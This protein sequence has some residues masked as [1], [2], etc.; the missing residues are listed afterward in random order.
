MPRQR[1]Q[2][3]SFERGK[4]LIE[5][6]IAT[7]QCMHGSGGPSRRRRCEALLIGR[8]GVEHRIGIDASGEG[9]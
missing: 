5:Q 2:P 3:G 1:Q 8:S 4:N 6:G 7:D 9:H